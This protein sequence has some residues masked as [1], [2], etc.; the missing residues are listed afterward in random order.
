MNRQV[1]IESY[2][3]EDNITNNSSLYK[4]SIISGSDFNLELDP[5]KESKLIP[6]I[7]SW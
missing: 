6:I 2:N 1:Y 5:D 3:I 7:S 4:S